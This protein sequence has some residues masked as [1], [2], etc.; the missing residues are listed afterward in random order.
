MLPRWEHKK[1]FRADALPPTQMPSYAPY[2]ITLV[3]ITIYV[4]ITILVIT[5]DVITKVV[6]SI[7]V[8]IV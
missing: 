1:K 4:V 2:C 8:V 3:V 7:V 6:I 5:I